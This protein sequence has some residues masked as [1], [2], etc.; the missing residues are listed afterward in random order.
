MRKAGITQI[1][2]VGSLPCVRA[3]VFD[4]AIAY[5]EASSTLVTLVWS[6]T[7]MSLQMPCQMSLLCKSSITFLAFIRSLTSVNP[8]VYCKIFSI[9]KYLVNEKEKGYNFFVFCYFEM[10]EKGIG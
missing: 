3:P 6:V 8:H 1:T 7:C 5:G 2:T 9:S 10:E 4:Q